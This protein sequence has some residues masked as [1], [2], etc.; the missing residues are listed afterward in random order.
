MQ[1]VIPI[2]IITKVYLNNS[3]TKYA[4]FLLKKTAVNITKS[5]FDAGATISYVI[6]VCS[7]VYYI[8]YS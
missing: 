5:Q 4:K 8:K 3:Y 7:D 1:S 6:F 2:D